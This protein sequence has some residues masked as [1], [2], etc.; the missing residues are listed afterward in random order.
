MTFTDPN[1]KWSRVINR[2]SLDVVAFG[3][4]RHPVVKG[5]NRPDPPPPEDG[6]YFIGRDVVPVQG[7]SFRTMGKSFG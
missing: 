4:W 5:R 1:D 3:I 7:A 2:D 6:V